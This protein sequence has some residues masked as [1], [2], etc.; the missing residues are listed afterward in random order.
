[1]K[2]YSYFL[3]TASLI[4]AGSHVAHAGNQ[5][6]QADIEMWNRTNLDFAVSSTPPNPWTVSPITPGGISRA[7]TDSNTIHFSGPLRTNVSITFS[8][9]DAATQTYGCDFVMYLN[10]TGS[11]GSVDNYYINRSAYQVASSQG[12]VTCATE[13][14]NTLTAVNGDGAKFGGLFIIK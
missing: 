7:N 3:F 13:G 12:S 5:I 4:F 10:Y 8:Y 11:S 14:G 6:S 2:K 1:M 9:R